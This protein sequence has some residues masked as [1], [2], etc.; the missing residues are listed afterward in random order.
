MGDVVAP[1]VVHC[2]VQLINLESAGR[3]TKLVCI[4]LLRE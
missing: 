2:T 3:I 1:W 4:N